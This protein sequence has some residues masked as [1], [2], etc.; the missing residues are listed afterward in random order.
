MELL[1]SGRYAQVRRLGQLKENDA[2]RRVSAAL[3]A[4]VRAATLQAQ[5]GDAHYKLLSLWAHVLFLLV[6]VLLT[7]G[8]GLVSYRR[9]VD[10]RKLSEDGERTVRALL[11]HG[12][13][14]VLLVDAA[15]VIT[16]ASGACPQIFG[17]DVD[18]VHNVP[19]REFTRT[20]NVPRLGELVEAARRDPG[21]LLTGTMPL[22]DDDLTIVEVNV[23]DYSSL[24][25]V[26]ST[27]INV[28]DITERLL[29]QAALER[30]E[31]F[32]ANLMEHAPLL[33]YVKDLELRF[34]RVNR[35]VSLTLGKKADDLIGR[36]AAEVFTPDI[37]TVFESNE[38]RA[39]AN[40][41][42]TTEQV[43]NIDGVRTPILATYFLLREAS[44]T[45]YAVAAVAM[46][47]TEVEELRAVEREL[48]VGVAHARDAM[49]TSYDGL[50]TSWNRSA[51]EMFG[52]RGADI[53]G[54]DV[55][56]LVAPSQRGWVPD[57]QSA[58]YAG[59]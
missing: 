48:R 3:N 56:V 59:Q 50:I 5:N 16:F 27:I 41:E 21:E 46:D 43:L 34:L 22:G 37:A 25:T 51:E 38:R 1:T 42:F 13:D 32:S 49:I 57:F 29:T 30:E 54:R 35:L 36:T 23:C 11:E 40:G 9:E 18:E 6:V 12:G 7:G 2:S 20:L 45:P 19:F 31:T 47:L 26:D 52:Y 53:I 4:Q 33:I 17:V 14:V 8:I 39:I 24:K 28:R 10:R 58:V 15:G 44:G 55:S